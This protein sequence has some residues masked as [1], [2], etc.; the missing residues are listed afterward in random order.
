MTKRL[1]MSA[2]SSELPKRKGPGARWLVF[3]LLL[4]CAI[5]VGL[6]LGAGL[7]KTS[8]SQF[9][10]RSSQ[11]WR[12][13]ITE[14]PQVQPSL[15]LGGW[16]VWLIGYGEGTKLKSAAV[17]P[18]PALPAIAIVIDDCGVD[19]LRTRTAMELPAAMTLA[20]LP[21]P[22]ASSS[23][24]R[25]AYMAGHEIIVHLPMEPRGAE[26]PGPMPLTEGLSAAEIARRLEWAL[27]RV[28]DYDGANNHMGSRFTAS[29]EALFSVMRE[30]SARKLFFLDSRTTADSQA[31]EVAREAGMLTGARDI[32]LDNDETAPAVERALARLEE[33]ARA[34]GSVIAIGH[35]HAETLEALRIWAKDVEARGFRLVTLKT[36]LELRAD[37]QRPR[38]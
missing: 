8:L 13:G 25:Q 14:S 18:E 2:P 5:A 12:Q 17:T 19:A 37:E 27:A 6:A 10:I 24:S 11:T 26:N 29:R 20:F 28:S 15:R 9:S 35:P 16:P 22:A 23:L 38:D 30:L 31:E 32:F 21:Y 1:H 4:A 3:A 36:V 34:H 7:G 33:Q